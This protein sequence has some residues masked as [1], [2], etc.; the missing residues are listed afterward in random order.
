MS[1]GL[2]ALSCQRFGD[3]KQA[4]SI[5]R[6]LS[7]R[8]L[9]SPEEGMYWR[10]N[11][12]G[13]FWYQ[14]PIETQ[15]LMIQV[16]S[17]TGQDAAA[18]EEMKI[19]LLRHKQTNR[20]ESTKATLAACN[21]LLTKGTDLLQ[22]SRLLNVALGGKALETIRDVRPEA[23]TGLVKT[24][25]SAQEIQPGMEK[26]NV[27]N[28]NRGIAWGAAYW[29]YFEQ[30]DKISGADTDVSIE[31]Q[32]FV[33]QTSEK[34]ELLVPV[35]QENPIQVGNEVVVRVVIRSGRDMEF[36]HLKD[37]RAS[38]FEP[39]QTLSG[40]R[41]QDGLGYYQEVKDVAHNFFISYLQKG[42]YVFEYSLRASHPGEFSNGIT[43]LQCLY[44]PELATHSE[45]TRVR[46]LPRQENN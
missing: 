41:W 39:V 31:K 18:V 17:E 32:L 4:Q 6:S 37:M 33:K 2:L 1:Q 8:A 11:N 19:W 14:S 3:H 10:D 16:F 21:A 40:Y 25:F 44:A 34:G 23:G 45:G 29:Q 9:R 28:P 22:E 36:V 7:D 46:I 13:Y 15:A 20:W 26:I 5:V 27:H 42:S 12:R 43:T 24:S 30:L 35:S 38:G